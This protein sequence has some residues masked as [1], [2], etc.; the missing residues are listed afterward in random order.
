MNVVQLADLDGEVKLVAPVTMQNIA[1]NVVGAGLA[2][3]A[4]V[5]AVVAELFE[6][7]RTP[8]TIV[9][10]PRLVETWG[11]APQ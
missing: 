11:T 4:E 10:T 3:A 1:D 6:F 8:N 7:A 5:D 9:S 2:T